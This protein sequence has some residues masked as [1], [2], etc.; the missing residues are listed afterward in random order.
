MPAAPELLRALG[1][2]CEPPEPSHARVA[3]AL[4]LPGRVDPADHT[5]LFGFQL[6]PY[7][8]VYLGAEGML[9]GEAADRVAGFWRALRLTPPSEPDHLAA[10]LGL[11]ATLVESEHGERDAAHRRLWRQAR[12][13]LL[14]EHVLTWAV[15]YTRAVTASATPFH[16]AWAE[17]LQ[18][19]LLAEAAD[20]EPPATPPLHLRGVPAP[21][22]PDE[23]AGALVAALLAPVRS[24]LILTRWDLGRAAVSLGLGLRM[25]ERAF[26]LRSML[27]QDPRATLGWLAGEVATWTTRHKQTEAALGAIGRHWRERAEATRNLLREPEHST[28]E[29]TADAAG[30]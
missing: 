29:M 7:A 23:G 2:L 5:E 8:S 11:Y 25:G 21:P 15:A 3:E 20:L 28:R 6:V 14:W 22:E 1:V 9:G 13:A 10:L 16:A 30:R 4:C 17:L 12:S 18:R 27:D 24:G 26:A 19:T